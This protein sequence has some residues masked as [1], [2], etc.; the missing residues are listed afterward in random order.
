MNK[1]YFSIGELSELQ[2][3]SRQTL[4]YY[5]KIDLFKPAHIDPLTG[6]RYYDVNQIDY[7]DTIC[8]M[9]RIGFSLQQIKGQLQNFT[10]DRSIT[11]L[12]HQQQHITRQIEQLQT[13]KSRVDQRIDLLENALNEDALNSITISD[14][15]TCTLLVHPVEAPYSLEKVSV[16]TKTLFV[17]AFKQKLP[18]YYQSGVI[19]PY[20]RIIQKEY[21]MANT[22][23]TPIEDGLNHKDILVI[24]SGRCVIAYHCGDYPSIGSTYE[25]IL[26]YCNHHGLTIIS[27][28]YEFCINDYLSSSDETEF[29][30][31]IMFYIA[32]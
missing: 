13:I 30:T 6:Y 19:V 4:I 28:S 32:S 9:K 27:D 21:T 16:A 25:K 1:N 14:T 31:K 26:K 8:I 29:I 17:N 20:Q 2:G 23:F 7:L 10:L 18:I 24:P 3:I 12:K 11:A 22:V 5:D 15:S